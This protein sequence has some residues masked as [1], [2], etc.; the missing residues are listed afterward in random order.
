MI[1]EYLEVCR[2]PEN[3]H[4]RR[5]VCIKKEGVIL[6]HVPREFWLISWITVMPSAAGCERDHNKEK[7]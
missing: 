5:A 6:G 4:D 7:D 2:E 1:G 3:L